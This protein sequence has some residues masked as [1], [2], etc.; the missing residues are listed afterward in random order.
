MAVR[1]GKVGALALDGEGRPVGIQIVEPAHGV[2]VRH[3]GP[4]PLSQRT[5]GRMGLGEAS[6]FALGE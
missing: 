5:G 4:R 6:V 3:R 1:V 2:A